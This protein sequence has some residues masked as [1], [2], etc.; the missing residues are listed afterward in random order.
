M[1]ENTFQY[2]NGKFAAPYQVRLELSDQAIHIFDVSHNEDNGLSFLL[3]KCHYVILKDKAFVY[4]NEQSI[5]YIVLPANSEYYPIILSGIKK[6]QK[7][8]Y[9]QLMRQK[10]YA[11]IFIAIVLLVFVFLVLDKVVPAVAIKFISVNK[12]ISLGDEFYRTFT[13]DAEI[14]SSST[15]I[16]QKF[17]NDLKLSDRYPIRVTVVKDTIVNAFALPGGHLVVY[18]GIINQME[19]PE[20]LVALLSHEASHVNKRHSLQSILSQLTASLTISLVTKDL[21]GLSKGIISN[22]NMLTVLSY[23]RALESQADNEGMQLMVNNRINPVGMKFLMEDLK[24]L[25]KEVPSGISFL[26]THPLTDERINNADAFSKNYSQL[27]GPLNDE[28]K[29]LWDQLKHS[30]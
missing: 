13:A 5:D 17:A 16:L 3:S 10:W 22:V 18:T 8:W 30:R 15:Y 21:N 4:L 2:F 11:L 29:S 7:G 9:Y 20:E 28:L 25:N 12:E 1:N 26:S 27:N 23:S 19:S 24:K 6:M 14:D